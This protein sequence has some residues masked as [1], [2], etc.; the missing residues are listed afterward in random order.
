MR[1]NDSLEAS[2]KKLKELE[3]LDSVQIFLNSEDATQRI[4]GA[5]LHVLITT[6]VLVDEKQFSKEIQEELIC[7]V[8]EILDKSRYQKELSEKIRSLPNLIF[9]EE[10]D[11][12]IKKKIGW[13][14]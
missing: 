9:W 13:P 7:R 11:K 2:M 12:I 4:D 10:F 8:A 5:Y 3:V 1:R 6:K 14:I